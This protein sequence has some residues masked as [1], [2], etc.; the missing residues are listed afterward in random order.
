MNHEQIR[1]RTAEPT[2]NPPSPALSKTVS[3]AV[4]KQFYSSRSVQTRITT[5]F[6]P[7]QPLRKLR[8]HPLYDVL[9]SEFACWSREAAVVIQER[10]R[11]LLKCCYEQQFLMMEQVG[12][13]YF[14]GGNR[15]AA[16]RRV[17]LLERAGFLRRECHAVLG[18]KAI[19]RLTKAGA[20]LARTMSP[21]DVSQVTTLPMATLT[22]DALVTSVRLRLQ[23]FWTGTWLPEKALRREEFEQVPDGVFVFSSGKKVAVEVENSPKG[24]SRLMEHLGSW[25]RHS[26]GKRVF[27][28]L[29]IATG[30]GIESLLR[31]SIKDCSSQAPIAVVSWPELESQK[32]PI[33]TAKGE[34]DLFTRE[35]I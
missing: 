10:D 4:D 14:K 28:V 16:Y 18:G 21:A 8:P 2:N 11:E 31:R 25:A 26:P 30:S 27:F 20:E 33:W 19:I 32:P 6:P 29:Y 17:Q 12:R 24:K 34:I 35:E 15:S 9:G 23:E 22:H 5:L 1:S 13:Y 7:S 3:T